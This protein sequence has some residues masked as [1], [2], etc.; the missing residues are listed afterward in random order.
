M[1]DFDL[2][3]TA[4]NV[5]ETEWLRWKS[6][7]DHLPLEKIHK[8]SSFKNKNI[9]DQSNTYNLELSRTVFSNISSIR[10]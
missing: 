1:S 4:L 3:K 9:R 7:L 10:T 6:L 5:P 2:Y 8:I